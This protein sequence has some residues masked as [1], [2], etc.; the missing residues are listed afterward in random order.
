MAR[1]ITQQRFRALLEAD[2]TDLKWIIARVPFAP[3]KV[4]KERQGKRVKGT[5]N[6]FAFR[7]SLFGSKAKGYCVLVNKSMQKAAQAFAGDMAAFALEPD[8]EERKAAV[9]PELRRLLKQD[10]ALARWFDALNYSMRKYMAD[11]V[12]ASK[13]AAIR[14]R[15]AD[16]LVET[17]LLAMEGEQVLPPVLQI[18]FRRQPRAHDGWKAMTPIQRRNHLMGI[19][20]YQSPEARE[21]RAQKAVSEALRVAGVESQL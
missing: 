17:M 20:H 13:T 5:I 16:Q 3:E 2:G 19:F 18:A 1:M 8:L 21:R 6:G 15:R 4:W 9:P 11:M 10:R 7:T 14:Q 12:S